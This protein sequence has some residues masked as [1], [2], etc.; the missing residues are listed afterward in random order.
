MVKIMISKLKTIDL[1]KKE[2]IY[3]YENEQLS[4]FKN[5]FAENLK[6]VLDAYGWSC[7]MRIERWID[8]DTMIVNKP[9]DGYNSI[10][11]VDFIDKNGEII[12]IDENPATFFEYLISISFNLITR[13]YTVFQND[14]LSE[15][16]ED[17]RLFIAL[18]T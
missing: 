15:I 2:Q 18:S 1:Y 5:D 7:N 17:I 10:I 12:E 8:R 3:K 4:K 14:N 13:K 6:R 9:F 16:W 11:Q